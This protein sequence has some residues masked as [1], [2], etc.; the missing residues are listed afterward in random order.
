MRE[1]GLDPKLENEADKLLKEDWKKSE[2]RRPNG[3]GWQNY[4]DHFGIRTK[5]HDEKMR[6]T[7]ITGLD[8]EL[9]MR[10]IG[11]RHSKRMEEDE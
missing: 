11:E 5:K 1:F 2:F 4:A 9:S 3:R 8:L 7:E 6:Q 10:P